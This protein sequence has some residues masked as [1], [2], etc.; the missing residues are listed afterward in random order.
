MRDLKSFNLVLNSNDSTNRT[1]V[2][3][4]N[5]NYLINWDSVIP[6]EYHK[7]SFEVRFSFCSSSSTQQTEAYLLYCDFGGI[8]I[9]TK[10]Q[11]MMVSNFLGVIPWQNTFVDADTIKTFW[12]A[13]FQFNAPIVINYPRNNYLSVRLQDQASP[14]VINLENYVLVLNFKVIE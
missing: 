6:R 9:N 13:D 10:D 2:S 8:P 11:N 12:Q 4:G 3:I 5:Y 1:G 14:F 7:E